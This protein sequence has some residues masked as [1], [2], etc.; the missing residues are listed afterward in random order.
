M[1]YFW[2]IAR[3]LFCP[4]T[5]LFIYLAFTEPSEEKQEQSIRIQNDPGVIR[6]KSLSLKKI[7]EV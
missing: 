4:L 5:I 1:R 2:P 6:L 3:I 7:F